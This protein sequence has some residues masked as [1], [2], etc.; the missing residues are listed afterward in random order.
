MDLPITLP[1]MLF[2]AV[3]LL[4][5]SYNGRF[6]TLAGL[7]RSLHKEYREK[8]DPT[9]L[10]QIASL[11]L[12]LRLIVWMQVAGALSFVAAAL[13]TTCIFYGA[14]TLGQLGFG[15]ALMLLIVSVLILLAEVLISTRALSMLL[16]Q[17]EVDTR[18]GG[19]DP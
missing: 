8:R 7:V 5:L 18:S 4:Y 1:A 14:M 10:D 11:R 16:A 19:D 2:P 6:L 17:S 13:S 3:S 15:A 9:A 12:R